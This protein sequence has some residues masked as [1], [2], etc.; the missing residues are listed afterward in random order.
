[1]KAE[2]VFQVLL[3]S[4][5]LAG[6]WLYGQYWKRAAVPNAEDHS[7]DL[8]GVN[9]ELTR[10]LDELRDEVAQ[11]RSLLAKG[12]LAIPDDLISF[13]EKDSGMVFLR[14]P[15][16]KLASPD[17]LRNAA[18]R[19][20]NLLSGK[21]AIE[22]EEEAWKTIGL[23]P[24]NTALRGQWIAIET[25]DTRGL[26]DLT[27]GEILLP[28]DFDPVSI[29][30]SGSLVHQLARQLQLQ[31]Y[32]LPAIWESPDEARAWQAVHRGAASGVQGRYMLRRTATEDIEL[33]DAGGY[34]REALLLQLSPAMQGFANFPYLEGHR[35]AKKAYGQSR[36]AYRAIFQNRPATSFEILHPDADHEEL[37]AGPISNI[38]ALGLRLLLEP[39]VGNETA[40]KIAAGWLSDR[41]EIE[42]ARLN[43]RLVFAQP[44]IAQS[45]VEGLQQIETEG[46]S[47]NI[48]GTH[49]DVALPLKK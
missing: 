16:A 1:M 3:C 33:D 39:Y 42:A 28:E 24:S 14:A 5:L 38:G 34:E 26:F 8:R 21:G 40:D 20:L 2:R 4:G 29:P 12:S 35:F 36:D 41:Y 25:I 47:I 23:I 11:V 27:S 43:W 30:D 48:D 45:F 31:N 49:V 44:E 7:G 46:R 32:P 13:V 18:E 37:E 19:N 15:L 10:E 22:L 17:V 6:A 9:A